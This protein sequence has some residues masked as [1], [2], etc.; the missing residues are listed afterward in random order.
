MKSVKGLKLRGIEQVPDLYTALLAYDTDKLSTLLSRNDWEIVKYFG[1]G[2][3]RR[4]KSNTDR[5]KL[6][7][8]LEQCRLDINETMLNKLIRDMLCELRAKLLA[9]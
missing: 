4:T 9:R 1:I 7:K 6:S 2:A 8:V 5:V 3:L